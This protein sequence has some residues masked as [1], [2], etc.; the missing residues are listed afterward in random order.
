[1]QRLTRQIKWKLKK[2]DS[3]IVLCGRDKGQKGVILRLD[4]V[5]GRAIVQGVRKAKHH[6]K[7]SVEAGSGGI[8]EKEASIHLSNVAFF[9]AKAE[10]GT[11]LG[12]RKLDDGSKVRFSKF[13]GEVV[14]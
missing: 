11:R 12:Y 10:R 5:K 1:M 9:D 4:R 13:S 2:G 14:D 6:T 8:V 7:P 3:V